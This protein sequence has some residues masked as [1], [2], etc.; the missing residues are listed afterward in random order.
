MNSIVGPLA[1]TQSHAFAAALHFAQ[2]YGILAA[3]IEDRPFVPVSTVVLEGAPR[4]MKFCFRRWDAEKAVGGT[5]ALM[6]GSA[7]LKRAGSL[8]CVGLGAA[9]A[10]LR[11]E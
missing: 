2:D 1:H 4:D 6:A 8:R 10:S 5:E 11:G 7:G 3:S 9:L